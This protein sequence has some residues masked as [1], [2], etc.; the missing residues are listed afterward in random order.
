MPTWSTLLD[1]DIKNRKMV[2]PADSD[3]QIAGSHPDAL[4]RD[5]YTSQAEWLAACFFAFE[6]A[7]GVAP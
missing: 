5:R 4:R 2:I 3:L 6:E 1:R 7:L